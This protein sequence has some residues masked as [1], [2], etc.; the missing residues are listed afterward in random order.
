MSSLAKTGTRAFDQNFVW[1]PDAGDFKG[2]D[3]QTNRRTNTHRKLDSENVYKFNDKNY[4]LKKNICKKK[5]LNKKFCD[6]NWQYICW[7]TLVT[8]NL[9]QTKI[10]WKIMLQQKN[11]TNKNLVEKFLFCVLRKHKNVTMWFWHQIF[12]VFVTRGWDSAMKQFPFRS[13][14]R[15][16]KSRKTLPR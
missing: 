14:Q 16:G 9:R 11:F 12:K 13:G 2:I 15:V 10:W 5:T 8:T 1:P 4:F 6:K 3:R 7:G